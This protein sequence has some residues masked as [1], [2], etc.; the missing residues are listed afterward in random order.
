[1]LVALKCAF[2]GSPEADD[3]IVMTKLL[4]IPIG[5]FI[6]AFLTQVVV[7][8]NTALKTQ[9]LNKIDQQIVQ[10]K[11]QISEINQKIYLTSSITGM[12]LRAHDMGF[13]PMDKPVNS[14]TS[15]TIAR[16]F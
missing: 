16:A 5:V 6:I 2:L 12:E 10:E 11:S 8:N 3:E 14:V 1:M 4:K 13:L 15:P 7:S 9:E